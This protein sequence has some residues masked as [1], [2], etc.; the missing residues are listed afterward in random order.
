MTPVGRRLHTARMQAARAGVGLVAVLGFLGSITTFCPGAEVAWYGVAA[1]ASLTG[2]LSPTKRLG[3]VA[4]VLEVV[5]AGIVS[6]GYGR[7]RRYHAWLRQQP[8]L[9]DLP[10]KAHP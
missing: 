8:G 9:P 5:L 2:L 6:E 4:V 1:T 7:G 10:P 3:V